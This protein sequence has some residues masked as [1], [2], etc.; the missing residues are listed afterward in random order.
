[1][2]KITC[3]SLILASDL[4]FF[5]FPINIKIN[6]LSRKSATKIRKISL[7]VNRYIKIHAQPFKKDYF[8]ISR[9][10]FFFF[11]NL[12]NSMQAFTISIIYGFLNNIHT[13]TF[14]SFL[15]FPFFI[16]KNKLLM[17]IELIVIGQ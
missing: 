13:F 3:S 1:M 2:I 12:Y 14:L 11:V 8:K 16:S 6:K 7:L 17:I 4:P 15:F 9:I 5:N 10:F